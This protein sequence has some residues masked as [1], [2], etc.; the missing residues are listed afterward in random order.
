M[1]FPDNE[2]VRRF[3]GMSIPKLAATLQAG[4]IILN[5]RLSQGTFIPKQVGSESG[6]SLSER[7]SS[8]SE[9]DLSVNESGDNSEGGGGGQV[10]RN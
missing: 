1:E 4:Q 9:M 5:K 3:E 7:D 6:E 8:V 10:A 2:C